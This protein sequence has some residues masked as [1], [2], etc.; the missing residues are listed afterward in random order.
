MRPIICDIC[1]K[2]MKRETAFDE[3]GHT[4]DDGYVNIEFR[5]TRDYGGEYDI[6]INCYGKILEFVKVLKHQY[7][8]K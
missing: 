3:N 4:T 8:P 5:E 1:G 7:E 2:T 6:C